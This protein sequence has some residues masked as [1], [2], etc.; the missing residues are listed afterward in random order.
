MLCTTSYNFTHTTTTD[1]IC[2]GVVKA[3]KLH[4][5]NPTQHMADLYMME[6]KPELSSAFI[7]PLSGAH[8]QIECV[9]VDG[10]TDEGPN[11]EEV[12][13]LWTQHHI[14]KEK[15]VTLVTTWSSGSS[16]L[17][18]VKL[19]YGCLSLG[20]ANTFI[21]SSI[22]GSCMDETTGEIDPEKLKRNLNLAIDAYINR[23]SLQY[24]Y[25][26]IVQR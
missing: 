19:Q 12:Q 18:R 14:A 23:M 20:H 3:A 10:A 21:P 6:S 26:T 4:Q 1:E 9:R 5:K 13:F 25:Y 8:K 16:F 22:G 11:H 7:N 17:N 24:N 2:V 15:I